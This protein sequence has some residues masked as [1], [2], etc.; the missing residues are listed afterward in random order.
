MEA[1][2]DDVFDNPVEYKKMVME[3]LL[4]D[5]SE[6]AKEIYNSLENITGENINE[7]NIDPSLDM[8]LRGLSTIVPY[9]F[10]VPLLRRHLGLTIESDEKCVE[11]L[12]DIRSNL[13]NNNENNNDEKR[14]IDNIINFVN[15]TCD[16]DES[17]VPEL[18]LLTMS[19][20]LPLEKMGSVFNCVEYINEISEFSVPSN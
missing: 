1:T 9:N 3:L 18:D 4:E 14:I 8:K 15:G 6:Y 13:E 17:I 19:E 2:T 7:E 12:K 10:L 16:L 5:D 20:K 11:M